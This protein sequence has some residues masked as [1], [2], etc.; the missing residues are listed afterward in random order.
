[1]SDGRRSHPVARVAVGLLLSAVLAPAA[2]PQEAYQKASVRIVDDCTG[3]LIEG[4]SRIKIKRDGREE[5][6]EE[7]FGPK[8]YVEYQRGDRIRAEPNDVNYYASHWVRCQ[9]EVVLRVERQRSGIVE[10][11]P[12]FTEISKLFSS[13]LRSVFLS[14]QYKVGEERARVLCEE[15]V[16]DL[17]AAIQLH[18]R[19]SQ[20]KINPWGRRVERYLPYYFQGVCQFQSGDCE[21]ALISFARSLE[22]RQIC[23][24]RRGRD[25]LHTLRELKAICEEQ[26]PDPPASDDSPARATARAGV[27]TAVGPAELR[28]GRP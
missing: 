13:A 4:L 6:Y 19:S 18:S 3:E 24:S 15:A 16:R 7:Q 2:S 10:G 12:S 17:D 14:R 8:D 22:E 27:P 25:E 20:E 1:M 26:A 5:I 28:R 11:F 9:E 21:S 23:V